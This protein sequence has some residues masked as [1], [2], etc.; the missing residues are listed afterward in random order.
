MS[1]RFQIDLLVGRRVY[2]SEGRKLGRVDEVR[3]LREG[4]YCTVEGLL[5]GANSMTERLG[6]DHIFSKL[7]N[8]LGFHPWNVEAHII[9][10]EQIDSIEEKSIKLKARRGEV[11]TLEPE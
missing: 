2:D 6:V 11:Q 8:P 7:L 1:E 4:D 5:T 3:L 10:W 9:Y